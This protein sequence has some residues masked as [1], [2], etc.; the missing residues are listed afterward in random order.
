MLNIKWINLFCLGFS[1]LVLLIATITDCKTQKIPN[2]LTIPSL[3][4]GGAITH[5]Y[6]PSNLKI[7]GIAMIVLFIMGCI[8]ISGWGDIKCVMTIFSLN[9][10]LIAVGMYVLAQVFLFVRYMIFTPK[11]ALTE[12]KDNSKQLLSANVTIDETKP[13]YLLAP[14]LL[15]GYAVSISVFIALSIW[16]RIW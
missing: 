1:F 6:Y 12:F 13:K 14:F 3:L 16:G 9:N 15:A 4:L 7:L 11:K 10:W 2:W 5:Y 8:G